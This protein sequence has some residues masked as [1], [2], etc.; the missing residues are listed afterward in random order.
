MIH[1][2]RLENVNWKSSFSINV[3]GKSYTVFIFRALI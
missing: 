2:A 1:F 3:A